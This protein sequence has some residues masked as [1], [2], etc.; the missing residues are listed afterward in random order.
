MELAC[1]VK[2][3]SI[4]AIVEWAPREENKEADS[5]ANGE[6]GEFDPALRM[7]VDAANLRWGHP[8]GSAYRRTKG[9]DQ[10][11]GGEAVWGTA[12]QDDEGGTLSS[13]TGL[14]RHSLFVSGPCFT[15]CYPWA[16]LFSSHV[17]DA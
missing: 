13:T 7:P 10:T 12:E 5:L 11:P 4:R 2:K 9:R 6:R 15:F 8:A 3:K 14:K 16:S 1:H 17:V